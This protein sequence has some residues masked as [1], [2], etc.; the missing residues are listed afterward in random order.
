MGE[1]HV[2]LLATSSASLD[3]E[4]YRDHEAF[5]PIAEAGGADNPQHSCNDREYQELSTFEV[6][7]VCVSYACSMAGM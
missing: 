4:I 7:L 2:R 6:L 3:W 1:A 5:Y